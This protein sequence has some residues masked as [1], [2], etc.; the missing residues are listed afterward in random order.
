MCMYY[1]HDIVCLDMYLPHDECT[2]TPYN[3]GRALL[4]ALTTD[5]CRLWIELLQKRRA[6]GLPQEGKHLNISNTQYACTCVLNIMWLCVLCH[7]SEGTGDHCQFCT[8]K[9]SSFQLILQS[10]LSNFKSMQ[11]TFYCISF[12]TNSFY[13]VAQSPWCSS[14]VFYYC[15]SNDCIA[16]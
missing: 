10:L 14:D 8:V 5:D 3:W 7:R 15:H 11:I 12:P 13:E 2:F 9:G 4:C 1:I 6:L 16:W